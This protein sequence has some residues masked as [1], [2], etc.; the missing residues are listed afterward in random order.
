M[1]LT[2]IHRVMQR[3][4]SDSVKEFMRLVKT[5]GLRITLVRELTSMGES[6]LSGWVVRVYSVY[7]TLVSGTMMYGDCLVAMNLVSEL[8][9]VANSIT[10]TVSEIYSIATDSV[11]AGGV[12]H[13]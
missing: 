2:N 7:R 13:A 3:R 5:K 11:N 12:C 4:F 10:G 9:S 1:R 8:S 6:L